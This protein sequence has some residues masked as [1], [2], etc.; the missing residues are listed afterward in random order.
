M[1]LREMGW[2]GVDW[3][4]LVQDMDQWWAVVDTVMDYRVHKMQGIA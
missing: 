3:I 1:D 4:H 2:E